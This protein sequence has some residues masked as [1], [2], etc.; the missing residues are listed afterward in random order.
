[1]SWGCVNE[2][3]RMELHLD[4]VIIS[5]G[6]EQRLLLVEVDTSNGT[7]VFVKLLQLFTP[8]L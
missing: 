2:P 8:T 7:F 1:M 6:N 4:L 3:L 5:S